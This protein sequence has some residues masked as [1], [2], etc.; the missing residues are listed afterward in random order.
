M[1]FAKSVCLTKLHTIIEI[2]P[3]KFVLLDLA[4]N[5]IYSRYVTN[6]FIY[7]FGV[8]YLVVSDSLL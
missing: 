6:L 5:C 2:D 4:I 3:M 7:A 8:V 1:R